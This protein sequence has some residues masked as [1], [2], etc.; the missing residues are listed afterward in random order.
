MLGAQAIRAGDADDRRR[1]RHGEHVERAVLPAARRAAAYR[2]GNEQL[3]DLMIHDGLW[4]RSTTTTWAWRPSSSPRSSKSRARSRTPSRS[5]A[6]RRPPPRST[7]GKF[8]TEIV[9]VTIPQQEG[10]PDRA[11]TRTSRPRRDTTLEALGEARSRRSRRA[12]RSPRAT[13]RRER[14][15]RGAGR[16]RRARG[17]EAR[18]ASSR[19][20]GSLGYATGGTEPK[21]LFYA[22]V[23]AVAQ[24]A[25]RRSGWRA[26][27]FDLIE[28][29]EAF[30]AQALADGQRA[31]LGLG[32]ASTSTAARSRSGTRSARPARASWSRCC[33]RSKDRGGE[34]AGSPRSAWAAATRSPWR[35]SACEQGGSSGR[36]SRRS[37]SSARG[38]MGNGIAQVFAQTGLSTSLLVDV[39]PARARARAGDDREEPRPAWSRRARSPRPSATAVLGRIA[40][41]RRARRRRR[42][43]SSWSRRSSRTL[44]AQEASSSRELDARRARRTRSWPR[45]TSSISI[46]EI[47]R[48]DEARP[49]G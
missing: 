7:A 28:V 49:T 25:G 21:W 27:D 39:E 18:W 17:G 33:T 12:A 35:S 34:D 6:T 22:P 43:A 11:S 36:R 26:G 48:G 29:N 41:A 42:S 14:R 44:D 9:P 20:R 31:G 15:R 5:R 24:A 23:V 46:T 47:A 8:K 45:N 37:P 13:P 2:L 38:T 3:V 32:S 30:A 16:D 4:A 10:R 40:T 19:S 1:G